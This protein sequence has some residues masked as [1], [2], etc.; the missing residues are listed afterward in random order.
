MYCLCIMFLCKM[1]LAS[2]TLVGYLI[3]VLKCVGFVLQA[4]A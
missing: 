1:L 2:L 4:D 3:L